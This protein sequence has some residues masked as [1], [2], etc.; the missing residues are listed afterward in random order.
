MPRPATGKTAALTC[1]ANCVLQT[2]YVNPDD[3]PNGALSVMTE[4]TM[5]FQLLG[6]SR[7]TV[8]FGWLKKEIRRSDVGRPDK[9]EGDFRRLAQDKAIAITIAIVLG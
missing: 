2:N 7:V 4:F 9:M 1:L 6:N 8:A 3:S 5:F